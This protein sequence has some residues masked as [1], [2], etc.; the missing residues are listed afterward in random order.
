MCTRQDTPETGAKD[1]K[2]GRLYLLQFPPILPGL[3]NPVTREGKDAV[4]VETVPSA[5]DVDSARVQSAPGG[6]PIPP[7]T[8]AAPDR[9]SKATEEVIVDEAAEGSGAQEADHPRLLTPNARGPDG[10]VGKLRVHASGKVALRWGNGD[11]SDSTAASTTQAPSSFNPTST[12]TSTPLAQSTL[13][14]LVHRGT[15]VEFLQDVVL[16]HVNPTLPSQTQRGLST[17]S[18][19]EDKK[20]EHQVSGLA[21]GIAQIAGKFIVTPDWEKLLK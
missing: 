19:Q 1:P 16:A 6:R 2:F 13:Q 7:P 9:P 4:A 11:T 21:C 10:L 14:L 3:Y 8:A 20:A 18:R 17:S 12:S 15:D 5:T